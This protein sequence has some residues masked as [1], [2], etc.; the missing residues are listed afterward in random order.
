MWPSQRALDVLSVF[1]VH[2]KAVFVRVLVPSAC[3]LCLCVPCLPLLHY[4]SFAYLKPGSPVVTRC[5][6]M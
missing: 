4:L 3:R 5:Y 2:Y 6:H 1:L